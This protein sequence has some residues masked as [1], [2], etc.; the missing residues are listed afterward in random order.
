MSLRVLHITDLHLIPE[1]GAEIYGADPDRPALIGFHH[2]PMKP[3]PST[4]CHLENEAAT[5]DALAAHKNARVV[6]TGHN[7]REFEYRFGGVTLYTTPS[8]CSQ[9]IH[10][11]K[12]DPVDH[13]NF[14]DSHSF[15][16]SR[17]GY[18]MLTLGDDG[19]FESEVHWTLQ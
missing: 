15:D 18:R 3:C 8:T 16:P 2:S 11:Q 19:G 14:W 12:G 10:A 17:Q 6:I 7:H 1:T 9:A 4:D 5:L 13:E